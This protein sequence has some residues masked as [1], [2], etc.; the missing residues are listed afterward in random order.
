MSNAVFNRDFLIIGNDTLT[1]FGNQI[2]WSQQ[3]IYDIEIYFAKKPNR[4]TYSYWRLDDNK[5]YLEKIVDC[6]D[7]HST[8]DLTKIY[9]KDYVNGRVFA[10]WVTSELTCP[11]GKA[12]L[13]T[14]SIIAY[15]REINFKFDNG[16]FTEKYEYDNSKSYKS[17]FTQN[18][19]T[20]LSFIYDRIN[21]DSLPDI[22]ED[23]KR[24]IV[25]IGTG[26]DK[27]S[28]DVTILKGINSNYDNEALRVTKLIPEWDVYY[29]HGQAIIM[30]WTLPIV[31]SNEMKLKYSK[32]Y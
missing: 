10:I 29:K 7:K 8:A 3:P 25:R 30:Y 11:K 22:N 27:K 15:E 23:E 28:F 32:R 1:L 17:I 31:F 19:D 21:W 26:A 14:N 12:I 5:L 4:C 13:Y 20:L 18:Q 16:N 2:P 6:E 24:I 9:G